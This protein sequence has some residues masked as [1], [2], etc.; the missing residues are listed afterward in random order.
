MKKDNRKNKIF[1]MRIDTELK[2][3]FFKI[4]Y[5][6]DKSPSR[7]LKS[8]MVEYIEK[9]KADFVNTK[10]CSKEEKKRILIK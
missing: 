1:S 4:C 2:E 5:S 9:N 10:H 7:V 3:Q 6:E 8:F